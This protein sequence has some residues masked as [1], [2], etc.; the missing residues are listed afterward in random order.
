LIRINDRPHDRLDNLSVAL[1]AQPMNFGK[2]MS[3]NESIFA[4]LDDEAAIWAAE[5]R[6]DP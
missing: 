2:W 1:P 4:M 3:S 5:L 6:H